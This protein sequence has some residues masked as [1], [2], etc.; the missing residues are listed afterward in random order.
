MQKIIEFKKKRFLGGLDITAL[1][2]KVYELGQSG[3][4]VKTI[5][6]ATGFY[7]Q[8]TAVLLLVENNEL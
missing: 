2:Q 5:T 4:Q 7:G 3:W 6:T 1:N 8:I